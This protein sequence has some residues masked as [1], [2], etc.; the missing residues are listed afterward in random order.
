LEIQGWGQFVAMID[1][2]QTKGKPERRLKEQR[3]MGILRRRNGR[4]FC[5]QNH[6]LVRQ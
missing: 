2:H 6:F 5:I 1:F 3:F 4:V